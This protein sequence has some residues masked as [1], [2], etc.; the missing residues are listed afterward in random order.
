MSYSVQLFD[1]SVRDKVAAGLALDA[2]EVPALH[3]DA[4]SIFLNR[5]ERYGYRLVGVTPFG[6]EFVKSVGAATISVLV[7]PSE[8]SFS[9]SSQP[10]IFEALQDAS[11]L[12]DRGDLALFDPQED[13]WLEA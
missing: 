8:I 7:S 9:A 3:P 6:Q 10:A 1:P 5:L 11:E 12:S 13:R 4:V 2:I